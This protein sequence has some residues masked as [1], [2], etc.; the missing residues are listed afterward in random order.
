MAPAWNRRNG[1]S[2]L[3]T[4]PGALGWLARRHP[5][6]RVLGFQDPPHRRGHGGGGRAVG[7]VAFHHAECLGEGGTVERAAG[8]RCRPAAGG[9]V[10]AD[11]AGLDER[12]LDAKR[13]DL[14]GEGLA[15]ALEGELAGRVEGLERNRDQPADRADQHDAPAAA[16]PHGG[17]DLLHHPD[18]APEIRL[19]LGL[20]LGERALLRGAGQ[21]PPGGGD[22]CIDPAALCQHGR[23]AGPDRFVVVD[24]H[25]QAGAPGRGRAPPACPGDGP[26]GRV[27]HLGARPADARRRAGDQYGSRFIVHWALPFTGPRAPRSGRA[28]LISHSL[29]RPAAVQRGICGRGSTVWSRAWNGAITG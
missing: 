25:G 13:R 18:T 27:Q 11:V 12:H 3:A 15:E 9:E 29:Q 6:G 26:A 7:L 2:R 5:P 22:Q 17:Q 16:G 4:R 21:A 14:V 28:W 20:G 19:Q 24:V 23:H 1:S 10:G 8:G